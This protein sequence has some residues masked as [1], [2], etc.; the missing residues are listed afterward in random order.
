MASFTRELA[1]LAG[2][3][4]LPLMRRPDAFGRMSA[5]V[6]VAAELRSDVLSLAA[7]HRV[8]VGELSR[9]AALVDGPRGQSPL[10]L[11]SRFPVRACATACGVVLLRWDLGATP[12]ARVRRLAGE[13][14]AS[15]LAA[16]H[17]AVLAFAREAEEYLAEGPYGS[18]VVSAD[19]VVQ[20][21]AGLFADRLG[22]S[23]FGV[24]LAGP[25]L[26]A[27]RAADL[28]V[29]ARALER[30]PRLVSPPREPSQETG[31]GR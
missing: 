17:Q 2:W 3:P 16:T 14:E 15:G 31:V 10:L 25:A 4:T 11:T 26:L 6:E 12:G 7:T 28:L 5:P 23:S 30:P 21:F 1:E 19:P 29:A 22:G 13:V 9:F 20:T 18:D 8:R 27:M 24:P